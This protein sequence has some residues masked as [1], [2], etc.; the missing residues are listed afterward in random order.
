MRKK[1]KI[2]F[3]LSLCVSMVAGCEKTPD[4]LIVKEKGAENI[5]AYE[6]GEDTGDL[7]RETLGIPE[8]YIKESVYEDGGL[9]ID[10]DAEVIV[11]DVNSI[12]TVNVTAREGNQELIDTVTKAFFEGDK[13]YNGVSYSRMTK[14]EIEK[15]ITILKKYII[16][17][18]KAARC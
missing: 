15:Q 3:V 16:I 10:T 12:D 2:L 1:Y 14:A 18:R 9:V 17:I 7:L 13:I 11:P 6:S 4:D 8:H 5:A